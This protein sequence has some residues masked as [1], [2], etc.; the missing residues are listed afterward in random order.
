MAS[1]VVMAFE[2]DSAD[3][4]R[5]VKDYLNPDQNRQAEAYL[6]QGQEAEE[7]LSQDAVVHP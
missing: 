3:F 1:A 5:P 7:Y 6:D 2:T 4:H